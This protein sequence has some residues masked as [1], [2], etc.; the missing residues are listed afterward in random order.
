MRSGLFLRVQMVFNI[1]QVHLFILDVVR[2]T[3]ILHVFS[4][5]ETQILQRLRHI[6]DRLADLAETKRDLKVIVAS[7]ITRRQLAL[8]QQDILA[9][10]QGHLLRRIL[11]I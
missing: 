7:L 1:L 2:Y 11:R 6:H 4:A 3:E 8:T 5:Q 9:C 10:I